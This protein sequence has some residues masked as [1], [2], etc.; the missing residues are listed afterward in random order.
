VTTPLKG[1][2]RRLLDHL[3][4]S[5]LFDHR[6]PLVVLGLYRVGLR[7]ERAIGKVFAHELWGVK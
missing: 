1:L 3:G 2:R 6:L 4:Q 5:A 7:I